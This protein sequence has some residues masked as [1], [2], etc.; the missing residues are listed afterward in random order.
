M[1][2]RTLL[3]SD[4]RARLRHY[5]SVTSTMDM[6]A[7]W[8]REKAEHLS[9]VVAD[10][11][12]AGR[13][14]QGKVWQTFPG[15]SLACTFILTENTGPHL[16]LLA[17]VAA[18]RALKMTTPEGVP[19]QLK[20]PNDVLLRGP[21][22]AGML[23]E[24]AH[25]A[26]GGGAYLLGMGLNLT[27]SPAML[28]SFPGVPLS[29][30][31]P[32]GTSPPGR[33]KL[34]NALSSCLSDVLTLYGKSDWSAL[35]DEYVQNCCTIGQTVTWRK[36]DGTELRGLARSLNGDGALELVDAAG[37]VHLV[38]SGDVIAQG[39]NH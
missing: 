37:A 24:K 16:P 17:G 10:A 39:R 3:T 29:D 33:E 6:A 19:L 22:L 26:K 20:W 12:T 15:H 18:L 7:Q 8:L 14:R 36:P 5:P 9:C 23:V 21:K 38:H 32:P 28:A 13:G 11:Q 35:A 34:L 1:F 31:L 30:G 27:R 2:D 25:G 4:L